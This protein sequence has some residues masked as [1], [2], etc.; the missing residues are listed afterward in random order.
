MWKGKISQDIPLGE[1]LQTVSGYEERTTS[2][3]QEGAIQ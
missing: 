2:L 1:D 3:L